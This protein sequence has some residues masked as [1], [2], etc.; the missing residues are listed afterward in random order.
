MAS[1]HKSARSV[2]SH[3]PRR[4]QV[5]PLV[6]KRNEKVIDRENRSVTGAEMPSEAF[7]K[8]F[9]SSF[10]ASPCDW[11]ESIQGLSAYESNGDS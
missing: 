7:R 3:R 2:R 4:S 9:L 6:R 8:N 5:S 11:P 10:C 1:N